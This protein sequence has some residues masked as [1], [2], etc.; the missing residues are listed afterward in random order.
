M[1]DRLTADELAAR[2]GTSTERINDLVELGIIRPEEGEFERRDVLKVRVVGQLESIGIEVEALA[3]ARSALEDGNS[4]A[5]TEVLL[6]L[7]RESRV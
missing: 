3:A 7:V 2:S 4:A 6:S 5:A 1:N